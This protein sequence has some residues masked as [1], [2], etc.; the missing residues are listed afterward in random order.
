VIDP[1]HPDLGSSPVASDRPTFVY[2]PEGSPPSPSP[3]LSIVTRF[4]GDG[5]RLVETARSLHGQSF[6]DWEWL[7]AV[8]ASG[9]EAVQDLVDDCDVASRTRLFETPQAALKAARGAFVLHLPAGDL[10]EPTAAEKWLWFLT[11][12]SA[13]DCV[14]SFHVSMPDQA[15]VAS[16]NG[17]PD[18]RRRLGDWVGVLRREAL[19]TTHPRCATLPEYL[20]WSRVTRGEAGARRAGDERN[21]RRRERRPRVELDSR[22]FENALG[23]TRPRLLVVVP[24]V[25]TGG[26]DKFSV[27]LVSQLSRRDWETTVVTTLGRENPW[28]PR[29]ARCTPDVFTLPSF[30]QPNDYPRFLSYLIGSRQPDAMLISNSLFGYI[31]LPYLRRVARK[32][33]IVDYSHSVVET[34]LDGGYPRLSLDRR[35]CLDLQ[36][37]SSAA[38]KEWMVE[39]GGEPDRIEVC[40]IGTTA[41]R[42]GARPSR[43]ELGLLERQPIILYPCRLTYEKQPAVFARTLEELRRRG[44][45]FHALVVGDGPYLGWLEAFVDKHRLNTNVQFLGYQPNDRVRELMSVADCV[46]LPSKYEGISAVFYEAMAEGVPV[47]GADVGGQRELVARDCGVLIPPGGEDEEVRRYTEALARLIDDPG[48]RTAMGEAARA[49]IES[50]FTVE[51]MGGRMEV[52]LERAIELAA[53]TPR[54]APTARAARDAAHNA[55]LTARWESS[56]GSSVGP[57]SWR[58]R[59]L[60]YRALSAVAMPAYRLGLRLGLRWLEPLKDRVFHA[61]FP[62]S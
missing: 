62:R 26:A 25:T 23:K 57:I 15:L 36:I 17:Q 40:Y 35:A 46:F 21:R 44:H 11:S 30:L 37:T 19:P 60:V 9:G 42:D 48:A 8:D 45:P 32:V 3:S 34:W 29:I 38:L 61:L 13:V 39:R 5:N 55:V 56:A 58:L 54:E 47:V 22:P 41:R 33:A 50:D 16:G 4:A 51:R 27:D 1:A 31:A 12:H 52:L 10:L 59:H 6:Q 18:P 28:L 7:V 2:G 53:S 14:D 20:H 49:R 24:F 43:A